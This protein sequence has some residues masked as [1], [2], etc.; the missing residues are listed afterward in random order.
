VSS[1][2]LPPPTEQPFRVAPSFHKVED[3]GS[4]VPGDFEAQYLKLFSD[5]LSSG[6]ITPLERERLDFAASALGLD[7]KRLERLESALLAAYEAHAA[8]SSVDDTA[9]YDAL[10]ETSRPVPRQ[11]SI[12]ELGGDELSVPPPPPPAAP[13]EVDP[14]LDL[15]ARFHAAELDERFR[16]AAVLVR[17]GAARPEEQALYDVHRPRSPLRPAQ[18]LDAKAWSA[19]LRHPDEDAVVGDIFG[20]IASSVL[21]G[22]ITAL[23][24]DKLLERLDPAMK[25]D[26][27]TS[28]VSAT[29]AIAWAAA[30][31]GMN[32]PPIFLAPE[33]DDGMVI[34]P[35]L[36]PALRVGARMLRGQSAIQLAF[37]AARSLSWL[38]GEH[39]VCTLVAHLGH[40]E[41]LFLAAL[42]IGAPELPMPREV[43]ARIDVIKAAILPVLEM[44]HIATLRYHVSA[45][46]ER[47][48]RTSLRGWARGTELT[49]CRAGLVLS[50]DLVGCAAI[51]GGEP[52]GPDRVRDL[53]EFW[54][55]DAC[56]ALR[57]HLGVALG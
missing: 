24:R 20:V 38:R 14:N 49:A 22:R 40:L 5:A 55:G 6:P 54:I 10:V 48:G 51:V 34:V 18:P 11:P 37:H 39:F 26:P 53:E 36:P 2:S 12:P 50:G 28:T 46:V 19:L 17:R 16:L 8:I 56:A 45:F 15:H 4:F 44:E 9:P 43:R 35:A 29:R 13:R 41:D 52:G 3:T 33:R 21:L 31:L 42:R 32:A 1:S 47:G 27:A 23:R 57:A 7:K 25:Q 30:T